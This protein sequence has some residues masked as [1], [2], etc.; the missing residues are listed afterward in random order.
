[1]DAG[2]ARGGR[3]GKRGAHGVERLVPARG[4]VRVEEAPGGLLAQ[5]PRRLAGVVGLDHAARHC[6]VSTRRGER[7]RAEPQRVAVVG[8]QRDPHVRSDRVERLPRGL[9]APELVAPA[10]AAQPRAAR[11]APGRLPHALERLG[12]RPAAE[13]AQLPAGERPA[14]EVHVRVHQARDHAAAG[15]VDAPGAGRCVRGVVEDGGDPL[16]RQRQRGPAR[17]LGIERAHGTA[18]EDGRLSTVSRHVAEPGV[19]DLRL[20]RSVGVVRL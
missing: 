14:R 19:P 15:E 4:G 17:A 11:D 16:A 1:V 6:Q 3:S 9:L 20:R 10:A 18:H 8:A 13:E 7:R 5:D 2:D 12:Q